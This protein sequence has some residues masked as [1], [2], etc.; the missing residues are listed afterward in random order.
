[1]ATIPVVPLSP[2]SA[3]SALAAT[4]AGDAYENN[5]MML[6]LLFNNSNPA[7]DIS[8]TRLA[9]TQPDPPL[10]CENDVV[11][12]AGGLTILPAVSPRWFNDPTGLVRI[13][14][15]TSEAANITLAVIRVAT[16]R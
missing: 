16:A 11:V 7:H 3:V 15:P 5:G 2:P 1:M 9:Q 10:D 13:T 8:V 12:C 14:Y 6:V 4:Q